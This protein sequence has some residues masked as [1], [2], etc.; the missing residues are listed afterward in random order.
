[1]GS[2]LGGRWC[3][4]G[5]VLRLPEL[6]LG[7]LLKLMLN[8][9]LN[10]LLSLRYWKLM[11]LLEG[12]LLLLL[13]KVLRGLLLL[14]GVGYRLLELAGRW[15]EGCRVR[16]GRLSGEWLLRGGR[17]LVW[18]GLGLLG[19]RLLLGRRGGERHRLRLGRHCAAWLGLG[20]GLLLLLCLLG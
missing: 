8:G 10:L 3:L 14:K 11:L 5:L 4:L 18:R 2:R 17:R 7:R 15:H 9:D 1:M 6:L 20:L 19:C 12:C 16:L 13:V